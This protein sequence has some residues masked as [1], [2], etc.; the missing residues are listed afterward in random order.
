MP[1]EFDID[2]NKPIDQRIY[3]DSRMIERPEQFTPDLVDEALDSDGMREEF[4]NEAVQVLRIG[5]DWI[6]RRILSFVWDIAGQVIRRRFLGQIKD[7]Y[8]NQPTETDATGEDRQ[9]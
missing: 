5:P 4:I 8:E 1:R 7:V 2:L 3:S 6:E 9:I